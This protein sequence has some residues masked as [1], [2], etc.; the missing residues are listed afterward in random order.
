MPDIQQTG[1]PVTGLAARP[2]ILGWTGYPAF[3]YPVSG[4]K[5]RILGIQAPR[6]DILL[7]VQEALSIFMKQLTIIEWTRLLRHKVYPTCFTAG[8]PIDPRQNY[9]VSQKNQTVDVFLN[10]F[11]IF[12]YF[13]L[14]FNGEVVQMIRKDSI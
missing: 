14:K 8:L 13:V 3:L 2:V 10:N 6:P 7:C 9:R 11:Q 4:C 1:Y 5:S 12:Q